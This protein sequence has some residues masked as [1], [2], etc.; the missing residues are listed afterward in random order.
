MCPDAP[1]DRDRPLRHAAG[2]VALAA[3]AS[4]ER[5]GFTGAPL[6]GAD[7]RA[8]R[9]GTRRSDSGPAKDQAGS[10]SV[11]HQ[12]RGCDDAGRSST[13]GSSEV[14]SLAWCRTRS[15][16]SVG[17]ARPAPVRLVGMAVAGRT[18]GR[19]ARRSPRESTCEEAMLRSTTLAV[20]GRWGDR[21][22]QRPRRRRAFGSQLSGW[23]E[24]GRHGMGRMG[25]GERPSGPSGE[26]SASPWVQR[27][28]SSTSL[29]SFTSPARRGLEIRTHRRPG[30]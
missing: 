3:L 18:I 9:L 6:E 8:S 26:R 21:R 15:G 19:P 20:S 17:P 16:R 25:G 5:L 14:P 23:N 1:R 10:M 13:P 4:E 29:T 24:A 7:R 27:G 30:G 11:A 28:Q 2:L 22:D 12:R